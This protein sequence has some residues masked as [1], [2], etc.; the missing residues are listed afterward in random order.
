MIDFTK[1]SCKYRG[2]LL[3]SRAPEIIFIMMKKLFLVVFVFVGMMFTPAT[4]EDSVAV[5]VV[6]ARAN[7][8][9]SALDMLALDGVASYP[10][11]LAGGIND[12]VRQMKRVEY[13][14]NRLDESA[15]AEAEAGLAKSA[16]FDKLKAD[17]R[18][19][20]RLVVSRNYYG[21]EKLEDA[22]DDFEDEIRDME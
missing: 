8:L 7:V 18:A 17:F 2:K 19:S 20:V 4:A 6:K 1:K 21:C 9:A 22:L 5:K 16:N 13:I 10:D 12:L 14:I 3:D 15:V 11:A